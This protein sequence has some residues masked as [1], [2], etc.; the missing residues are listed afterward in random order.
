MSRLVIFLFALLL[1][2]SL[3][4]PSEGAL[5]GDGLHLAIGWLMAAA[6][7]AVVSAGRRS[8]GLRSNSAGLLDAAVVAALIGGFW[9]STWH[10]FRIQGD[11]RAALNLAFEWTAIGAV[12]WIVRTLIQHGPVRQWIVPLLIAI[13]VGTACVGIA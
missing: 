1:T 3:M 2:A 4:W 13:G 11:R 12:W 8:V 5:H 9:L 7:T 6:C 10:V